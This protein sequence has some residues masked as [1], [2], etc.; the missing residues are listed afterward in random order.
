MNVRFDDSVKEEIRASVRALNEAWTLG[1]PDD[2]VDCFHP[3]RVV[4]QF[5]ACP[6]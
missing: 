2:L 3:D 6:D 1:K 4:D 5:S